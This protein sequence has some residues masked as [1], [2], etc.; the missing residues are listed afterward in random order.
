MV[1]AAPYRT[2]SKPEPPDPYLV[3]WVE[4]RRRR[5]AKWVVFFAWPIA[6]KLAIHSFLPESPWALY[7]YLATACG[8]LAWIAVLGLFDCPRCGTRMYIRGSSG[9]PPSE[10]CPECG[11][12]LGEPKDAASPE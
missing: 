1:T 10:G 9:D 3:A 2:P 7:V 4:Y 5:T 6:A 8:A 12:Q 11:L